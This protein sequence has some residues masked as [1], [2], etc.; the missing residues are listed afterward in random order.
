MPGLQVLFEH[1]A[2]ISAFDA[3]DEVR[4]NRALH[5]HCR[6]MRRS[7]YDLVTKTV[8]CRM[9]GIDEARDLV[10]CNRVVPHVSRHDVGRVALVFDNHGGEF[11]LRFAGSAIAK[12]VRRY[13][14]D[15]FEVNL[16]EYSKCSGLH[17]G[18]MLR[19][20]KRRNSDA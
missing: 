7:V 18:S 8:Q 1:L 12:H 3:D 2:L 15:R 10:R 4:S 13:E 6:N 19:F 17:L 16:V 9:H 5:R 11:L 14:R 20:G